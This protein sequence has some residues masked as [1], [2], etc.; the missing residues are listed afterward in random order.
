[1]YSTQQRYTADVSLKDSCSA[2]CMGFHKVSL[3]I[4]VDRVCEEII[5]Y[6]FSESFT[7]AH[8]IRSKAYSVCQITDPNIIYDRDTDVHHFRKISPRVLLSPTS[9]KIQLQEAK[10]RI[11][12]YF[13]RTSEKISGHY[14]CPYWAA[15]IHFQHSS[16]TNLISHYNGLQIKLELFLRFPKSRAVINFLWKNTSPLLHSD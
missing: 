11:P 4:W 8:S 13:C 14:K 6:S 7:W 3:I 1:M 5:F 12:Q 15:P 16:M 9:I 10:S 2:G